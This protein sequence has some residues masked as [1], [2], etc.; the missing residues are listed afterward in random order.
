[1]PAIVTC[2][3]VTR[4]A[5]GALG[6]QELGQ[7]EVEHLDQPALGAHQVRA[8]D[9]A[10][11]DPAR[12]RLVERVGDLQSDLDDLADRQ[13]PLLHPRRQ[14]LALDV[15]HHDEVGAARFADVV[16]DRDVGRTQERRGTRLVEQ[17]RPAVRIRL[18]L[19]G[20]ELQRDRT[21]EPDIFR[22]IHFAHPAGAKALAD[23]IVLNGR[24]N[25]G[26][27]GVTRGAADRASQHA[28]LATTRLMS[29]T[30]PRI[31][32]IPIPSV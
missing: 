11:H 10:M 24:T 5:F 3:C 25:Q 32:D 1:M 31:S 19:G 6:L 15:L 8:L 7:A 21:A 2:G 27:H 4:A 29:R 28:P 14:Q 23:A 12:V 13:R 17:A 26:V 22:S 9:V 16:G 18:E 30:F 20:E